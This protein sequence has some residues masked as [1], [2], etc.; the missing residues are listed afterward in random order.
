M[1]ANANPSTD[2]CSVA[3]GNSCDNCDTESASQY[4]DFR[5]TGDVRCCTVA[6]AA[7]GKT[8]KIAETPAQED[9]SSNGV[10]IWNAMHKFLGGIFGQR[11]SS[12]K[13]AETK[14]AGSITPVTGEFEA[15]SGAVGVSKDVSDPESAAVGVVKSEAEPE[16]GAVGVIKSEAEPESGAV[17]VVQ[18]EAEPESASVSPIKENPIPAGASDSDSCSLKRSCD[19]CS[20]EQYCRYSLKGKASCCTMS[21]KAKSGADAS[22]M[23]TSSFGKATKGMVGVSKSEALP[24]SGAVS[25]SSSEAEP[26]SAKVSPITTNDAEPESAKIS[27]I[28]E[29]PIPAW[30]SPSDVCLAM[31]SCDACGPTSY[32]RYSAK[33]AASCCGRMIAM[34]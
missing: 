14:A 6:K 2:S 24:E 9:S 21:A 31:S 11:E 22:I 29:N 3:P 5:P 10:Q 33:G 13:Q 17:G 15:E 25:P 30:A 27:P 18:A 23:P 1:P 8:I 28:T 26:E 19:V 32:C 12:N 34:K 20:S 7:A 4:C 16:S